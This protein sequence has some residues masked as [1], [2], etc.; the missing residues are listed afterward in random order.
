MLGAHYV[1]RSQKLV[2][3]LCVNL[4]PE[5]VETKSGKDV[6]AL[7]MAAGLD[8]VATVGSGPNRGA[9]ALENGT[10]LYVVS[11]NQVYVVTQGLVVKQIGIIGTTTGPVSMIDNNTQVNIF[12]GTSGYLVTVASQV[13]SALSLPFG[14]P[15]TAIIQDGFGLVN[16]IGTANFFQSNFNDLSIYGALAFGNAGG[17]PDNIVALGN[18]H[19]EV[20]VLKQ[21]CLEIWINAGLS[22][23]A[24]QRI[25]G[26]FPEVGCVA[27]ASVAKIGESLIW[28]SQ[29]NEGQGIVVMTEGYSPKRVSTHAIEFAIS[30]YST[31]TDAIGYAYQQEG[32]I[33]Y[34]LTFPTGNATW[35]FDGTTHLWHQRAAFLRGNLNRHWGNCFTIF[36]GKPTIGDY[37]T[38]NL[39]AFNMD[40]LTDNGTQRK[41]LRTWRAFPKPVDK[42]VTFSSLRIDMATGTIETPITGNPF[43]MLRWS[44]D[45]GHNWSN[46]RVAPVG[47]QGQSGIRVKF[48]RMGSTRR[49]SGLD[50]IFELSATDQFQ[51]ALIGADMEAA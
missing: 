36:N 42:P 20:W 38:G 6:G 32:H 26:V 50:R 31:I 48:N 19:R 2:D 10:L 7:F 5:L 17:R 40:T 13:L 8:L 16:Q 33:F 41:W 14:N 34:V 29:N 9:H 37:L 18:I 27:P 11:G 43:C 45:G 25:D 4:F 51:V 28:L 24:F 3:Q 15:G 21:S 49:N 44:D 30:K 47:T 1:S 12:D 39:Y 46:M 23:F 35:V 22:N